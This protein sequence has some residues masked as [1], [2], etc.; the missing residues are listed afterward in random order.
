M[1]NHSSL[2]FYIIFMPLFLVRRLWHEGYPK[3]FDPNILCIWFCLSCWFQLSQWK[4]MLLYQQHHK[5]VLSD[6]LGGKVFGILK[7]CGQVIS[8]G[9]H[10]FN[11]CLFRSV[12]STAGFVEQAAL[13]LGLSSPAMSL[14]Q[15]SLRKTKVMANLVNSVSTISLNHT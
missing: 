3:N 4:L 11:L 8:Q 6:M 15:M 14:E 2:C 7:C 5:Q 13:K 9:I 1:W 12:F 10:Y